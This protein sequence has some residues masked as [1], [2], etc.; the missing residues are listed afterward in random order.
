[1]IILLADDDEARAN[2]LRGLLE[3][4]PTAAVV[5]TGPST[6][7]PE[8]VA[9]HLPDVVI[10]GMA[11]PRSDALDMLRRVAAS[12]PRPVVMFVDE[13]DPQFME[14]AIA[15]GVCSYNV[16]GASPPDM[17]L[18]LR[19]AIALFRRH[20]EARQ[21]L[22]EAMR[23]LEEKI[24]VDRAKALLIRE[25]RISEPDAYRWLRRRAMECGRRIPE[26]ARELLA[27]KQ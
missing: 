3:Q 4:D 8:A 2:A 16:T 6:P 20:Q 12:D 17:R 23:R 24:L 7:L 21:Q 15:A 1:M 11:F 14:E 22:R 18:L 19:T 5:R 13:D 9:E 25:R 10:L 27:G 26:V